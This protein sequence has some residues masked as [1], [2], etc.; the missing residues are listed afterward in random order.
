MLRYLVKELK[1]VDRSKVGVVGEGLGGYTAGMV[2]AE[3]LESSQPLTKCALL[4]S[5]V[6]DWRSYGT[7]F[8]ISSRTKPRAAIQ[9]RCSILAWILILYVYG[10][11]TIAEVKLLISPFLL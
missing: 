9:R 8:F 2:M 4:I 1:F 7:S 6:V 5:P 11:D 10:A 3:D